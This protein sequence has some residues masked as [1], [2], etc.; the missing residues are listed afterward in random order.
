MMGSP[1]FR[2]LAGM[3]QPSANVIGIPSNFAGTIPTHNMS[4]SGFP[5]DWQSKEFGP[6]RQSMQ[7]Q[8]GGYNGCHIQHSTQSGYLDNYYQFRNLNHG[9][10]FFG[11]ML[12]AQ[13]QFVSMTNFLALNSTGSVAS[14]NKS[15]DNRMYDAT[16]LN[17]A[18][19]TKRPEKTTVMSVE[20]L[21]N[22]TPT[23]DN[24]AVRTPTSRQPHSKCS[25]SGA[26]CRKGHQDFRIENRKRPAD[27]HNIEEDAP[28]KRKWKV[29]LTPELAVTVFRQKPRGNAKKSSS[30]NL[31]Q[32]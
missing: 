28:N 21:L 20:G 26:S 22:P 1:S 5:L 13:K 3:N 7:T 29:V 32:R 25:L 30:I 24:L 15:K 31:S 19:S 16:M 18:P 12:P 9:S 11:D 23:A 27:N 8:F 10:E 17:I 4:F 2:V 14:A 6:S